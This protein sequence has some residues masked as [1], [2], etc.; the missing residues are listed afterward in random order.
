MW[1]RGP[2][3]SGPG[4]GLTRDKHDSQPHPQGLRQSPLSPNLRAANSCLCV[5]GATLTGKTGLLPWKRLYRK[6]TAVVKPA[7]YQIK[8]Y[9]HTQL[10]LAQDR[11]SRWRPSRSATASSPTTIASPSGGSQLIVGQLATRWRINTQRVRPLG[12]SRW[13]PYLRDTRPRRPFRT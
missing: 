5:R 4:G 2:S 10:S 9:T 7:G 6:A 11:D 8:D 1:T 13:R 12:R 3:G